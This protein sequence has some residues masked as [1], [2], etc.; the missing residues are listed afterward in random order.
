MAWSVGRAT[1]VAALSDPEIAQ[2]V[3]TPHLRP[4]GRVCRRGP[5]ALDRHPSGRADAPRHD[6]GQR[7]R[8]LP[9]DHRGPA[10]PE[11]ACPPVE[12]SVQLPG[13]HRLQAH[14][15]APARGPRRGPRHRAP[16][17]RHRRSGDADAAR[18]GRGRERARWHVR[19]SADAIR[20]AVRPERGAL[21]RAARPRPTAPGDSVARDP[22]A[23]GA[24]RRPH[25]G[26]PLRRH[27]L[28]R[29]PRWTRLERAR[30]RRGGAAHCPSPATAC[31][32]PGGPARAPGTAP[33][34]G[35]TRC[36]SGAPASGCCPSTSASSR[37]STTHPSRVWQH[38]LLHGRA[39][40]LARCEPRHLA[41]AR[42]GDRGRR[43]G[44]AG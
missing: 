6:R 2:Q 15:R 30:A 26:G 27:D 11:G 23:P 42:R 1:W 20:P 39:A 18:G 4:R 24:A 33:S 5:G 13:R 35:T 41:P 31:D 7:L 29:A 9:D 21:G 12:R 38:D 40:D 32:R 22:R 28:S 19:S 44:H 8:D 34:R 37:A 14:G 3:G 36:R 16:S 10:A 25:A 17:H 43:G